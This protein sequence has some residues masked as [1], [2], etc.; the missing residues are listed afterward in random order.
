MCSRPVPGLALAIVLAL[1]FLTSCAAMFSG[2]RHEVVFRA[3]PHRGTSVLVAGTEYPL[4]RVPPIPKTTSSVVF[5]NRAYGDHVVRLDRKLETNYVILDILFTPGFGL[6]GVLVDAPTGAWFK[7]PD[8]VN[9][10]F[11]TGVSR[12]RR[13]GKVIQRA[14]AP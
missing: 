5:R 3:S 8:E 10:D 11:A 6:V 9:F 2:T 4:S 12:Q 1:P 13:D 14:S 7:L